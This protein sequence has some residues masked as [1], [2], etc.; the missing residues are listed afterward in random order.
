MMLCWWCSV[1]GAC[2]CVC[3]DDIVFDEVISVDGVVLTM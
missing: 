2:V 1:D 3:V